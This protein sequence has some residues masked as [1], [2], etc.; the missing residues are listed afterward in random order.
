MNIL[1]AALPFF[2]TEEGAMWRD[3][4]LYLG[5]GL[6]GVGFV[7]MLICIVV[8]CRA[9]RRARFNKENISSPEQ[10]SAVNSTYIPAQEAPN[11][12]TV[13][14]FQTPE[15]KFA[16]IA[17]MDK[18]QF[19]IYVA[20][21]FS[22]KGY[23]VKL[24]PVM[25]NHNIDLLVEKLGTVTAVGCLL[26]NRLV[27]KEDVARVRDGKRYYAVNN[28]MALTNMYFDRS[29]VELAQAERISLADRNVL[30][31]QLMN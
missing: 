11:L 14:T 23:Q 10:I 29:A 3:A 7:A 19:V 27:S 12:I 6:T 26:T 16:E 31:N 1:Y 18:T 24:T 15:E 4:C 25:D 30:S 5:L 8:Y 20:R 22:H 13:G 2:Q 21:L 28:C 17:K 9:E